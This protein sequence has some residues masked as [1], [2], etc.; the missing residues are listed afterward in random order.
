M[1]AATGNAQHEQHWLNVLLNACEKICET[2][3]R[4][5]EIV[6]NFFQNCS[7]DNTV[8]RCF[9]CHMHDH[10]IKLMTNVFDTEHDFVY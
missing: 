9:T 6:R 8:L 5:V 3:E 4:A 10:L 1:T 2:V 7:H